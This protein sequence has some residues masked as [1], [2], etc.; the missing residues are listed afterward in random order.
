MGDD[1]KENIDKGYRWST[2]KFGIGLTRLIT[3]QEFIVFVVYTIIMFNSNKIIEITGSGE[4]IITSETKIWV[5]GYIV[6]CCIF[7]LKKCLEKVLE[8]IAH[9]TNINAE[10]KFGRSANINTDTAK[11]IEAVKSGKIGV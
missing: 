11:V 3:S 7:I 5:V 6:I 8:I 10:I 9:N 2:V 1:V 4:K